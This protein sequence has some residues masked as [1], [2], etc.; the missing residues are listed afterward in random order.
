MRRE[1]GDRENMCKTKIRVLEK[2]MKTEVLY[3][4]QENSAVRIAIN[5]LIQDMQKVCPCKVT[6]CS[7][8]D[9]QVKHECPRIVIATLSVS[10]LCSTFPKELQLSI[11]KIKKTEEQF[12]WESYVHK[13]IGD[14]LYIV[15]AD[16]RGTVFGIYDLC[17]QMGVSPW[18]FWADVPIRKKAFFELSINYE[19]VDWPDVQYRGI[20]LNDEEELEAWAKVHTVD[21]TIGPCTYEKIYELL[22]RLKGN[23]IWP[24]MHVNC[25]NENPENARLAERMGIVVGTSHCDMLLRSNQNEWKPWLQKKGYNDTVYDYSIEGRNREQIHEYWRESVETNRDYEVCYTV[26]MRGIH[27]SGFVTKCIEQNETLT[28]QEKKEKKIELLGQVIS[29]QRQILKEVLGEERGARAVQT[30]IPYKEVLD[31]YDGG[32]EVP[33]DITLIWVDDNFGYMRRY[34]NQKERKRSGGNGLYYHASYW[35]HPGMSY[36][37]FNSIPLA[38]TGN[39]LKKCWESGIQKMWVLNIGALKPLEMDIEYFLR[40]GWE[41]NRKKALTKDTRL[42]VAEWM[43]DNFSHRCGE[44][45]SIIYHNFAQLNNV[46]KPEHLMSEKYS[47]TAYGNE[48]KRRLDCLQTCKIEA[49]KIYEQLPDEEKPAFFQLFLMK[50]QASYFINASFYYADRSRFLWKLGAMQG[51]DA[52]IKKMRKMDKKKQMMLYYYNCVMKDGKWSGILTPESFSPPP[53]ALFPAGKPALKIGNAQLGVFCPEEILFHSRGRNSYEI[54]LFNK[55][56]GEIRYNVEYPQWLLV[57]EKAGRVAQERTLEVCILPQYRDACFNEELKGTIRITGENSEEYQIPVQTIL[58]VNYPQ[59]KEYY[60]EADGYLCIP[61]DG[62]QKKENDEGICWRQICDLGREDGNAMELTRTEDAKGI[63]KRNT[64]DYTIFVEH[65]GDFLFELYRFFT[66]RPGGAIKVSIWLDENEPIVLMSETID[67]WKGN[68]KKAVMNDGEVLAGILKNVDSGLHTLHVTSSDLY[69]TFSKIVIYTKQ[70]VESNMGPHVSPFYDGKLWKQQEKIYL[71]EE[72]SKIN[73]DEEYGTPSEETLLLPMLYAD[74]DFWKG[75]RL[76]TVSDQKMD[77]LA[78]EKY[79]VG[80]DG[81]KDVFPLFGSG[82]FHEQDGT[83]AI[84]AEYAL[85][86]SQNAFLTAG[87]DANHNSI[88]WEHT[89][90]ETDGKTGL[91]MMIE[92]YGLFWNNIKD[93]PGMHYKI[94]ICHS[95]TYILWMLMKFDDTDTDL[96]ALALDG[97][98][99][100]GEIYQQNGEFFTYS[101]KQRWHWRAVASFDIAKGEHILSVFGKKSCLRIDR[102]YVTNKREW[103][104]VDADWQPTKR[105]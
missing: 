27:D 99:L 73:W 28:E 96:C 55:G 79:S 105:I 93:A 87:V 2:G 97:H 77:R 23:Y 74:L 45:A 48:A 18:Y 7:K 32:L 31:L 16:R 13:M 26:G 22:L 80:E 89:Q 98:E 88:L 8:F 71:S 81:S 58:Q 85:E 3:S 49:E 38:Q 95:G 76:Y 42:F 75:E 82:C 4:E 46:C 60:A 65:S 35:A 70:K 100:N 50:I 59:N 90:A 29:D 20:F 34:P 12:R 9:S 5:N 11:E 92:P 83:L 68:W 62:Y 43:N 69:F 103:P 47:Q 84:E 19:K 94:Q 15:G 54:L 39:E 102:I 36:L 101:M 6:R 72:F 64:L 104:P 63:Q 37:F 17:R 78:P 24:A 61:A 53:T 41:A 25:F 1:E 51:A 10:E 66:L 52:C 21:G 33:E 91:A 40:Y 14:T 86:N 67:E 44:Q 57:T 56:K 30:F